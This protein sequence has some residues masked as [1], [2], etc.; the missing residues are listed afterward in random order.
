MSLPTRG[1]NFLEHRRT[2]AEFL[3]TFQRINRQEHR[4]FLPQSLTEFLE[5]V[6]SPPPARDRKRWADIEG[7]SPY[8][9]SRRLSS[10]IVS[11]LSHSYPVPMA[12]GV[13]SDPVS[14]ALNRV[15]NGTRMPLSGI[16]IR[17]AGKPS[18]REFSFF[19]Y[20]CELLSSFVFLLLLFVKR[21]KKRNLNL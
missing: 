9:R 14:R 8:V 2:V 21:K 11:F 6:P 16:E 3:V 4:E 1:N 17:F 10:D 18:Y 19:F 12:W 5:S 15:Y 13:V 20:D 7:G